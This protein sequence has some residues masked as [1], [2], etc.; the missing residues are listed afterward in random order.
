MLHECLLYTVGVTCVIAVLSAWMVFALFLYLAGAIHC[1]YTADSQPLISVQGGGSVPTLC[2]Q[3]TLSISMLYI[4]GPN[5]C[6][7]QVHMPA[8]CAHP[9]LGAHPYFLV[10]LVWLGFFHT[11]RFGIIGG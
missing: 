5:T 3:Q 4:V 7:Q 9:D 10:G 11:P 2:I 1:V 8:R 6:I